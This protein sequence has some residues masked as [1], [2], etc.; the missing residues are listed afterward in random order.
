VCL[1]FPAG[2]AAEL[3]AARTALPVPRKR[4]AV[5][6]NDPA[7][8]TVQSALENGMDFVTFGLVLIAAGFVTLIRR[9]HDRSMQ[10]SILVLNN[11]IQSASSA[12][13]AFAAVLAPIV[14]A[15]A[16]GIAFV[17]IGLMAGG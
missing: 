6:V 7:S 17:A 14:S 10:E 9:L 13:T 2:V 8:P 12:V 16:G 5:R 4:H 1:P 3:G 15:F 11:P